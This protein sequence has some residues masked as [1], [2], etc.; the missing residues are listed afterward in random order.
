MS[1][2]TPSLDFFADLSVR[3]GA[4]QEVGATVHGQRRLIPI[5]GGEARGVGWAAQVLPGGADFQLTVSPRLTELD[6]RYVLETD[7]G[8]R[9]YV[10]NRALRAAAPEVTA[11][12]LRGEPVDP[13]QVYFRCTPSFETASPALAWITERLFVGTGVRRPDRVEVRFFTVN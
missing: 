4:P 11:Q 6:A 12:L 2:A 8:D 1:L 5:L 13:A 7:G 9:I 3:V 10:H